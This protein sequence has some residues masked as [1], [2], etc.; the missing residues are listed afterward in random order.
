MD[1][2]LSYS[3]QGGVVKRFCSKAQTRT[4]RCLLIIDKIKRANLSRVFEELTYLGGEPR[5]DR[6]QQDSEQSV[7]CTS[8]A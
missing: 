1:G 7:P 5:G 3:L 6:G 2:A 8:P 4:G